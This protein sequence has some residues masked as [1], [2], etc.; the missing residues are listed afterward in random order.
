MKHPAA[1]PRKPMKEVL[2]PATENEAKNVG[3]RT[4]K[5]FDDKFANGNDFLLKDEFSHLLDK[6]KNILD[7]YS[8][9]SSSEN[10]KNS[11][12]QL[13]SSSSEAEESSAEEDSPAVSRE[14]TVKSKISE[15]SKVTTK[16]KEKKDLNEIRNKLL[17]ESELYEI[18]ELLDNGFKAPQSDLSDDSSPD[19]NKMNRDKK[20]PEEKKQNKNSE[21]LTFDKSREKVQNKENAQKSNLNNINNISNNLNNV[22]NISPPQ[23]TVKKS[24]PKP[25]VKEE[26]EEELKLSFA[27]EQK[28]YYY[29]LLFRLIAS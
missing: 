3:R 27:T 23:G 12:L 19:F 9:D 21:K 14:K 29:Y 28:V 10:D 20:K 22:T 17:K 26:D 11:K 15:N 2:F 18:D 7:M 24:V 13:S 5:V 16:V 4:G 1:M 25:Q 8:S 6:N